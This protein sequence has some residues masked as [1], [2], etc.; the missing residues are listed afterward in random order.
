M[1]SLNLE[2][3]A[4]FLKVIETGGFGAADI[5]F[6]CWEIADDLVGVAFEVAFDLFEDGAG[7]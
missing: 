6:E 4:T 7:A 5:V 2:S 1:N 3:V